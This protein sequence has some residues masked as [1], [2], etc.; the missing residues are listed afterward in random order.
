[1][2]TTVCWQDTEQAIFQVLTSLTANGGTWWIAY[3]GGLDS[4]VLLHAVCRFAAQQDQPPLVK[5]IHVNHRLHAQADQWAIHCQQQCDTLSV[6]LE[7]VEVD[8]QLTGEGLEGAARRAR[9]GAFEQALNPHD[10][11]LQGHHLNDQVETV[12]YRLVKGLGL[13]GLTGIPAKRSLGKGDLLRPLLT[14][15]RQQLAD[16]A[17]HWQLGWIEDNSNQDQSLDRNYLRYSVLP[18]LT[19]RWPQALKRIATAASWL[20]EA[21]ILSQDLARLDLV[22]VAIDSTTLNR[23]A[24]RSLSVTR[25]KNLLR[26]WLQLCGQTLS[27]G[28]LFSL[29]KLAGRVSTKP[30]RLLLHR[31]HIVFIGQGV[32]S[33]VDLDAMNS[34]RKTQLWDGHSKVLTPLGKMSFERVLPPGA[35]PSLLRTPLAKEVVTITYREG[36][37]RLTPV[38]RNGSC[39]LKKWL[40]EQAIPQWQRGYLPL[41]YYGKQLAAVADLVVDEAFVAEGEGLK[42]ALE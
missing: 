29:L 23:V 34:N 1:V 4:S 19:R 42:I 33:L 36:G 8:V 40:Q 13:P 2:T 37:E 24:F 9:Y 12:L 20:Q 25:Q 14:I 5:A 27:E 41:I 35:H 10:R 32:I 26:H 28:K 6:P 39:T 30:S 18:A 7:V 11:L 17:Q 38:G 15:S 16:L 31:E 3:S 22:S 21:H